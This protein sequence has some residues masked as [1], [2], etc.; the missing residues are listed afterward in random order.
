MLEIKQINNKIDFYIEKNISFFINANISF[1]ENVKF[2]KFTDFVKYAIKNK[3]TV[4]KA[5][6]KINIIFFFI[7]NIKKTSD[8]NFLYDKIDKMS[9]NS[10]TNLDVVYAEKT[11]KNKTKLNIK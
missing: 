3:Y 1:V 10:Y 8:I 6:N 9:S 2:N 5:E 4:I 7:S 11:M